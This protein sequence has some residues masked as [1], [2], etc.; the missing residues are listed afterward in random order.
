MDKVKEDAKM[1]VKDIETLIGNRKQLKREL[2]KVTMSNLMS[3]IDIEKQVG[4]LPFSF[5]FY[6][7]S[8]QHSHHVN[9]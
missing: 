8:L 9:I 1:H 2:S 4:V 7:S 3:Q 6:F 5:F